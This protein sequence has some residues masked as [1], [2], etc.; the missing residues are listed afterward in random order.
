M[1]HLHL[2]F[3]SLITYPQL[4]N[5]GQDNNFIATV[6]TEVTNF[7]S[8]DLTVSFGNIDFDVYVGTDKIFTRTWADL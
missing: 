4:K 2:K 3:P 5:G 1:L 7:E 8:F 6:P